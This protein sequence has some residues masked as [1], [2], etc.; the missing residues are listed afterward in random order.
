MQLPSPGRRTVLRSSARGL[1]AAMAMTGIRTLTGNLGLLHKS[2]PDAIVERHLPPP[3][4]RLPPERLDAL[5]ELA[6][7]SYGTL[8]GAAYAVLPERAK[9]DRRVGPLYG[10]AL[11][12][13]YEVVLAPLLDL[14]HT[15]QRSKR[16][17][18]MLA[19]DHA[20]YGV[21]V[22]GWLAPEPA[23]TAKQR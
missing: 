17:R 2:P 16:T 1:A 11:W 3:M 21:I 14:R 12:L 5:T 13:A 23:V 15:E 10:L 18:A 6:H 7:W 20:M 19:L 8:G 4:R 22:A 9:G